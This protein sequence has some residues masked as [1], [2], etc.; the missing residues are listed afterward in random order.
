MRLAAARVPKRRH[1]FFPVRETAVLKRFH[2]P[3]RPLRQTLQVEVIEGFFQWQLRL[4][5][6]SGDTLFAPLL[7]FEIDRLEQVPFV[8]ERFP[9]RMPG[10]GPEVPQ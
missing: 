2:L 9:F 4:L 1:V 5:Q 7:A 10:G 3:C 6:Q 8:A